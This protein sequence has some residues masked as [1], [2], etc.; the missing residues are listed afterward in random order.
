M[1]W[2]EWDLGSGIV[3][4]S[5]NLE[6]LYGLTPGSFGGML[7]DHLARVH[8]AD[9]ALAEQAV[10]ACLPEGRPELVP[11]VVLADGRVPLAGRENTSAGRRGRS[12]V[13]A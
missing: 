1:G 11:R 4:W 8:P 13:A 7:D 6:R 2:W 3:C 12:L 9:R 5:E 10:E